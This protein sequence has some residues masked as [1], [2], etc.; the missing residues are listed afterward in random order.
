MADGK[1][2]APK[3]PD[4]LKTR[5]L[6]ISLLP[7]IHRMAK[8]IGKGNTSKGIAIAVEHYY[9]GVSVE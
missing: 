1:A 7:H 4:H 9:E 8:E 5:R 3:K 6:S 2:G